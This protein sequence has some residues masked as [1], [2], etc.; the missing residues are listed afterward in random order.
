MAGELQL[1]FKSRGITHQTS[2]P[3]TPQQTDVQRGSIELCFSM[4]QTLK[5]IAFGLKKKDEYSFQQM[6]SSMKKIFLIVPER[7]KMDLPLF[8]FKMKI[9]SQH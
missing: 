6:L 8:L 5:A 9:C 4:N 1:F 2:V 3:H 7:K